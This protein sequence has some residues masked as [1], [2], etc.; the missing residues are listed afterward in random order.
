MISN[1][2]ILDE[3]PQ[4]SQPGGAGKRLASAR[5]EMNLS[6]QDVAAQLNLSARVIDAL[7]SDD[8]S[9]L[10]GATFVRGYLR[11]YAKLVGVDEA[12]LLESTDAAFAPLG[13]D[14]GRRTASLPMA[15][16]RRRRLTGVFLMVLLGL[17]AGVVWWGARTQWIDVSQWLPRLK[18]AQEPQI[19]P[20]SR[21]QR[22]ALA[23]PEIDL[24]VLA[25]RDDID[26]DRDADVSDSPGSFAGGEAS[27]AAPASALAGADADASAGI[28]ESHAGEATAAVVSV[29]ADPDATDVSPTPAVAGPSAQATSSPARIVPAAAMAAEAT[30]PGTVALAR[31]ASLAAV[32]PPQAAATHTQ[33]AVEDVLVIRT[34]AASWAEVFDADDNRLL[35]ALLQEGERRELE[36]RAPFRLVLGNTPAVELK[37]N[38]RTVATSQYAR[39]DRS[40]R[41][42]IGSAA[43]N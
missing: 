10:P 17:A 4:L 22:A 29:G 42:T 14:K 40:A 27:A 1:D 15:P 26:D 25:L 8:Y 23:T 28:D 35:Y 43:R 30:L 6:A 20:D 2:A 13:G 32:V 18:S 39:T 21:N 34:T 12:S 37:L 9:S 19:A 38:D 7:E 11:A 36:G 16:M 5:A 33:T 3:G 24:A 41:F 31:P